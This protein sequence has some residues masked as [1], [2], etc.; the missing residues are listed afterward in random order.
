[1]FLPAT[2][3]NS[4]CSVLVPLINTALLLSA[5]MLPTCC[6]KILTY[7]HLEPFLLI[8]FMLLIVDIIYY[9]H[10]YY[11]AINFCG[12]RVVVWSAW[13]IPPQSLTQF[14]RWEPPLFF[15][16]A[17]HLSSQGLSGPRA[18]PTA[19]QKIW[20]HQESYLGPLGLQP[21]SLTTRPQR[22]VGTKFCQQVAVAQSV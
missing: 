22:H 1:M 3:G 21:G 16:V 7:V 18:R 5:P 10:H 17:P 6:V 4:H 8:A 15:Q 12:Q 2:S 14:S 11:Y 20:Q 13:W 19:T 9:H